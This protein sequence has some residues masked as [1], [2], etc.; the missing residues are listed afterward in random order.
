MAY[1]AK[2]PRKK[3]LKVKIEKCWYI[4]IVDETD[5]EI[6]ND[7]CFLDRKEAEKIGQEMKKQLEEAL[8]DE[9]AHEMPLPMQIFIAKNN[10]GGNV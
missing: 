4:S 8:R 9:E 5:T 3:G 10:M 1:R 7:Y 6:D 2:R